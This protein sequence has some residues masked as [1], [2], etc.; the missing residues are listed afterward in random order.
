MWWGRRRGRGEEMSGYSIIA[1]VRL[2]ENHHQTGK[3]RHFIQGSLMNIP[4]ALR[5]IQYDEGSGY[6]LLYFDESGKELTDTFHDSL[7]KA[8][9]QAEMEFEV[10]SDEWQFQVS[11]MDSGSSGAGS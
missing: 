1:Y 11:T 6:F 7:E 2:T 4:S 5:I 3:T 8:L 10:Q 9:A